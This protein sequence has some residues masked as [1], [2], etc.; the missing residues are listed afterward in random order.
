MN[1]LLCVMHGGAYASFGGNHITVVNSTKIHSYAGF[2]V[3]P[4]L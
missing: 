3:V 2:V 4:F 1:V